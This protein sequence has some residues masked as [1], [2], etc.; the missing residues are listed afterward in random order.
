MRAQLVYGGTIADSIPWDE[1]A[2]LQRRGFPATK[3]T[4]R[5]ASDSCFKLE[6]LIKKIGDTCL[7]SGIRM[8]HQ[9]IY[10]FITQ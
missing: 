1:T 2:G 5:R 6:F 3:T 8:F 4:P 9:E 7:K 10:C